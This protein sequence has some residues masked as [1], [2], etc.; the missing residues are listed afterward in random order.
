[1]IV[2]RSGQSLGVRSLGGVLRARW[3]DEREIVRRVIAKRQRSGTPLDDGEGAP[4]LVDPGEYTGDPE[5]DEIKIEVRALSVADIQ[6]HEVAIGDASKALSSAE[7]EAKIAALAAESVAV[8]AFLRAAV[9]TI[10]GLHDEAGTPIEMTSPL[11]TEH[12]EILAGNR[13]AT[14]VLSACMWLQSVRGEQRKNSG[15]SRPLAQSTGGPVALASTA[16]HVHQSCGSIE[17]AMETLLRGDGLPSS[18]AP[19]SM[20]GAHALD[21]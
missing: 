17:G 14:A 4:V 13:L 21:A 15:A 12:Y 9:I 11:S 8:H 5:L 10:S 7:G 19:T 18:T 2:Y 20:P 6:R 1:M 16:T 3:D